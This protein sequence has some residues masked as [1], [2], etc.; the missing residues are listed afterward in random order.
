MLIISKT[1]APATVHRL[2]RMDYIG[3]K[4]L[5]PDGEVIGEHRFMG[6][7]TSKA[8]S[9]QA[10]LIP[11]LRLKLQQ[12]LQ[13]SEVVE[14]SYDYKEI[15]TIFNSM[16]KEELFLTSVEEIGADVQTILTSYNTDEIL[17]T[18]REDPLHRGVSTM[19]ILPEEKF[20][21]DVRKR[22]EEALVV[23][24]RGEVLNYRLAM[25]EGDQAR[26]HFFL[27]ASPDILAEIDATEIE[28][29]IREIIRTWTDRVRSGLEPRLAVLGWVQPRIPGGHRSR[30]SRTRH[31]PV[32]GDAS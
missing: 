2:A 4:K 28:A 9:E 16:P 13:N 24:L 22:I 10:D 29:I 32:G 26:L 7:F 8:Y 5:S 14:G 25:G 30:D 6:L 3:V 12:I 27:A 15:N 1:N 20:S 11:I 21:G 31:P 18:L 17:V 23:R 19:V